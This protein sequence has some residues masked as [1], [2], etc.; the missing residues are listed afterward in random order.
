[1]TTQQHTTT[2][3]QHCGWGRWRLVII[4]TFD[5]I[6]ANTLSPR[7]FCETCGSKQA[8]LRT[9]HLDPEACPEILTIQVR[10]PACLPACL[11]AC[12]PACLRL[13]GCFLPFAHDFG[14]AVAA[15]VIRSINVTAAPKIVVVAMDVV[16][17]TATATVAA[18]VVIV[19]V[20][21]PPMVCALPSARK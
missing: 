13:H 18:V 12:L 3:L 11:L 7:Y 21:P 20:L 16:A 4:T 6:M 17:A 5:D 9:T 15:A 2:L 10:L 8:A 19:I 14:V 1:M